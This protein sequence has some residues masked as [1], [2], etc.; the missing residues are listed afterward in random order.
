MIAVPKAQDASRLPLASSRLALT[1]LR[2][3][4]GAWLPLAVLGAYWLSLIHQLGA[5]WSIYEQYNYGWSVPFLCAYLIWRKV[6]GARRKAQSARRFLP[7]SRSLVIFLAL[8]YAP[9]RWLHE[10]NPVWR[11][12]S[13]L[14]TLEVIGI[15]FLVLHLIAEAN[16]QIPLPSSLFPL[17]SPLFSFPPAFSLAFPIC[18]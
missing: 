8:L 2:L 10:A 6:Q 13:L 16:A 12:T 9:T 4:L 11:L 17:P 15:T 1:A 3:P 14:L 7:W 5:Q 18:F